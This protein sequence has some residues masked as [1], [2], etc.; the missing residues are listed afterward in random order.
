MAGQMFSSGAWAW[1]VFGERVPLGEGRA[2]QVQ[3]AERC[4]VQC[5]AAAALR[6]RPVQLAP[7]RLERG[8]LRVEEAQSAMPPLC[9]NRIPPGRLVVASPALALQSLAARADAGKPTRTLLSNTRTTELATL[10]VLQVR[11]WL[12]RARIQ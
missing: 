1:M 5:F 9:E 10:G 12:A 7:L 2:V 6:T 3:P 4:F 8:L 11:R